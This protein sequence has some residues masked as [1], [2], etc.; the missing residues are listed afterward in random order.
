MILCVLITESDSDV[1]LSLAVAITLQAHCS[2]SAVCFVFNE[3]CCPSQNLN[4]SCDEGWINCWKKLIQEINL[5][6][7]WLSTDFFGDAF[8]MNRSR[9]WSHHATVLLLTGAR[10]L[11][12]ERYDDGWGVFLARQNEECQKANM[13]CYGIKADTNNFS[14]ISYVKTLVHITW[15]LPAPT[16]RL[17]EGLNWIRSLKVFSSIIV[18]L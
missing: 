10:S 6:F 16:I 4:L 5:K 3:T 8:S 2:D 11:T 1:C 17:F 14:A 18:C 13:P 15:I 7:L 9:S 12:T